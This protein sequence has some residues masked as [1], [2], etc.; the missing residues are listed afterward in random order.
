[1]KTFTGLLTIGGL[2]LGLSM[3]TAAQ[4][5]SRAEVEALK[6]EIAQLRSQQAQQTD[7][8]MNER[9][10]QEVRQIVQEVLSDADT[11]ASLL[12]EGMY[13]GHNGS[14]FFLQSADG[15]FLM[16]IDGQIQFRHVYNRRSGDLSD[17]GGFEQFNNFAVGVPADKHSAGFEL[18]RTKI[19][20]SGHIAD[21][22][23]KYAVRLAVDRY[24]N[25]VQADRIMIGYQLTDSLFI[26]A[27]E[28]KGPFTREE[29]TD[30]RYQLAAERSYI[31][32]FFSLDVVQGVG[33][34]WQDANVL[35]DMLRAHVMVNDGMRSGDGWTST[36]PFTQE[37]RFTWKA[38]N[39][40]AADFAITARA[41][42]RLAGEWSQMK[43]FTSFPG[44]EFA[45]FV[46]AALHWEVGRTGDTFL[47]NNFFMWTVDGSVEMNGLSLYAAVMGMH[48]DN[49][50]QFAG[51]RN[52]DLYGFVVQGAYNIAMGDNSL[53]PFVRYEY[54]DF[55]GA[56]TDFGMNTKNHLNIFTVGANYYLNRHA[57]KFTFDIVWA[58]DPIPANSLGAQGLL[59]DL[60]GEDDQV[61]LR[62]QFQ[63]LF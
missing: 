55:D 25:Y 39:E 21:P 5:V 30:S 11:R 7:S 51:V 47:N 19:Q 13:A 38:F 6:A 33:V 52:F 15:G 57:A 40:D 42:V 29:I 36:N 26:W 59:A 45:A 61:V 37:E 54:M 43:D 41:D 56:V 4:E 50:T 49:E 60:A 27:G 8:W 46:G 20:F 32:E 18:S 3:P 63:L 24:D 9:R 10:A 58:L 14:K 62:T 2:V 23:I 48:T 1:M 16:E 31:G 53:E 17:G 28:D 44:E 12:Q 34:I 22:R 35:N